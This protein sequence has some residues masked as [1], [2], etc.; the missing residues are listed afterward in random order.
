MK[1]LW[2]C[3]FVASGMVIH[4]FGAGF[5]EKKATNANDALNFVSEIYEY[6]EQTG[7]AFTAKTFEK[8]GL[9]RKMTFKEKLM[10]KAYQK[11]KPEGDA[12]DEAVLKKKNKTTGW[13]SLGF[14]ILG[15]ILVLFPVIGFVA[16]FA[17]LAA[18]TLG[19]MATKRAKKFSN[20]TESGYGLGLAGLIVGSAGILLLIIALA[21][22]LSVWG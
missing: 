13:L 22:V 21:L 1:K 9:Q 14:G 5:S 8:Y 6:A 10:F 16:F 17:W 12:K 4:T 3:L 11:Q 20:E 19:I 2:L 7:E 18:I 15:F